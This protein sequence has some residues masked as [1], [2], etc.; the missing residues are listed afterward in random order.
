MELILDKAMCDFIGYDR[1]CAIDSVEFVTTGRGLGYA[2][3]IDVQGRE[4]VL[5]NPNRATKPTKYGE[6]LMTKDEFIETFKT[7]KGFNKALQ[8][9]TTIAN[10]DRAKANN[11]KKYRQ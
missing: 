11:S 2:L 3:M 8:G 7:S 6:H 4:Y 5:G 9:I 1:G 10:W